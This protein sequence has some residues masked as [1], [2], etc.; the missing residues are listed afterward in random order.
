M[1]MM[2][3]ESR[4]GQQQQQQQQKKAPIHTFISMKLIICCLIAP[5]AFWTL[6]CVL[7]KKG[8]S[9]KS[10]KTTTPKTSWPVHHWA[11]ECWKAAFRP[12]PVGDTHNDAFCVVGENPLSES[13]HSVCTPDPQPLGFFSSKPSALTKQ[14]HCPPGKHGPGGHRGRLFS[15]DWF[16]CSG[17]LQDSGFPRALSWC[18]FSLFCYRSPFPTGGFSRLNVDRGWVQTVFTGRTRRY[19]SMMSYFTL[20][21]QLL[22]ARGAKAGILYD[23]CWIKKMRIMLRVIPIPFLM[24]FHD[25]LSCS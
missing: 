9:H 22:I 11:P 4:K 5:R 12:V 14:C 16:R 19:L 21:M 7:G 25:L 23:F 6:P 20:M 3:E 1:L 2:D 17:H 8:A 13:K 24:H 18:W 10:F 15:Q